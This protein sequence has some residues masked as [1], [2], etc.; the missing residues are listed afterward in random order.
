M[1]PASFGGF[2]RL[3]INNGCTGCRLASVLYAQALP[4]RLH[5]PFPNAGVAPLAKV[6]IHRRPGRVIV[7]QQTPG[8]SAAQH[9]K[10]PIEN[11]PH[12]HTSGSTSWRGLGNQRFK[13]GPFGIRKI[14]GIGF[15]RGS[16]SSLATS[17]SCICFYCTTF[18]QA[19]SS[20]PTGSP[21]LFVQPLASAAS[22]F[23]V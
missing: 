13:D 4:Q 16:S 14:T 3:A 1:R 18:L 20:S 9:R 2:D 11:L 19:A 17:F 15:H 5:H 7:G 21:G 22:Y 10:D 12:I 23:E 6:V 8:A